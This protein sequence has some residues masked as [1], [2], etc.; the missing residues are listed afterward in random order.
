MLLVRDAIVLADSL[1]HLSKPLSAVK[2]KLHHKHDTVFKLAMREVRVARE[3]IQRHI[4]EDII[5]QIDLDS[6]KISNQSYIDKDLKQLHADMLYHVKEKSGADAYIYFLWEHQSTYDKN[7]PLRLLKYTCNIMQDHLDA[8]HAQLPVVI[9]ALLY[10]GIRSPYP[11]SCDFSDAF[12]NPSLARAQM[13]KS[14]ALVDLSAFTDQ[15]LLEGKWS[16]LP[17]M[18]LKHMRDRDFS[19]VVNE[20]FVLALDYLANHNGEY[21]MQNMLKCMVEYA[22]IPD[23]LAFKDK[24]TM[25]SKEAGD[26]LMTIYD[27]LMAEGKELGKELGKKLGF[28][29]GIESAHANTIKNLAKDGFDDQYIAK[30]LSIKVSE[31]KAIRAKVTREAVTT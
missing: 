8:G 29:L 28:N 30:I 3:M 23:K 10:N 14:F 6:I 24:V 9:P 25:S 7:I 16:A 1:R 15:E 11:G 20:A 12:A 19:K 26:K 31:V 2:S 17:N 13:F 18:L 4:S 22:H 27:Q 21:F 5:S